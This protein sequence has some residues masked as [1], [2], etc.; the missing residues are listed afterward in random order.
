MLNPRQ[1]CKANIHVVDGDGIVGAVVKVWTGNTHTGQSIVNLTTA[2]GEVFGE[3]GY[4]YGT[5]NLVPLWFTP[6]QTY[7][8]SLRFGTNEN[9]TF[10]INATNPDQPANETTPTSQFFSFL[11]TNERTIMLTLADTSKYRAEFFNYTSS[12]DVVW[13]EMMTYSINLTTTM[14]DGES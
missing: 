13:G 5:K 1:T 12:G 11:L 4:A 7:N 6:G 8:L 3:R 10:L 14:N 2:S 9:M